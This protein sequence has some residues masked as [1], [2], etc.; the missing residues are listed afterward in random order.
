MGVREASVA[1][2]DL[3]VVAADVIDAIRL[4][5]KQTEVG[6]IPQDWT[7]SALGSLVRRVQRGASP[8]PIDD[9]IWFDQSSDIGWVR[10]S[11]VTQSGRYLVETTQFLSQEGVRRSRFLP[12]GTL[13]MSICATVGRPI[14]T[15]IDVCI[16]DGF[17]VFERPSVDQGFLYHVLKDLEPRWSSKGQTGSQMNLNTSLIKGTQIPLPPT[18]AERQAIAEALSDADA[19][20]ESL[21]QLIAKKR[22]IKQGA[23]QA[24]L[25]GQQRLP[26][27]S[28]EWQAKVL[29]NLCEMWSGGTPQSSNPD[30]Y[31]GDI[32]WASISD[33]TNGGKMIVATERTL[34]VAGL[35]NS[36]AQMFP[37]GTVLYAMYASLG[38]C[39]IAGISLCTSQAILGIK[40]KA[41]L[42]ADFLYHLLTSRKSVAKAMGQQG[43]QSNLNKRMVQDM[44]VRLP[45][46]HEQVAIATVLSDMDTEIAALE[47]RLAKTRDTKQGMMQALLTGAI[48]LPLAETA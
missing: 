46:L 19:L 5:Y 47:T 39:S 14:E 43:T 16:H 7:A 38:E 15:R 2:A 45:Q 40:V 26:G 41:R 20:I 31:D 22:Q 9:P 13:I 21:Q 34:T 18:K 4:G 25:T 10:I 29:G 17:V 6:P 35:A 48:R 1:Y 32:P 27:F 3:P 33:M 24:L 8:R 12:S 30:F 36:A 37:V 11:D 28:G 44:E 42:S 23:M